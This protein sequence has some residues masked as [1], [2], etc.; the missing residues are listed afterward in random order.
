MLRGFIPA[1]LFYWV[2]AFGVYVATK[3]LVRPPPQE[4][5]P[6]GKFGAKEEQRFTK[7]DTLQLIPIVLS[8]IA[9]LFDL[10]YFRREVFQAAL[11]GILV[12][13][14]VE[15]V[16]GFYELK[17]R[18][19]GDFAKKF[20]K[21]ATIGAS[22]A[23]NVG[24][25]VAGMA[26]I[27]KS[28]T[29]TALAPK[30]SY[31]MLDIAGN[32][33]LILLILIWIICLLFGL[34]VSTLIVYLLVVVLAAPALQALGI[35]LMVSHFVIFYFGAVAFI[36]PPT[37]PASL[38]ASGIAEESFIKTSLTAMRIGIPLFILPF[39]FVTHPELIIAG[40]RTAFSVFLIA[41]AFMGISYCLNS[42]ER[43][44]NLVFLRV[45]LFLAGGFIS[46]HTFFYTGGRFI[47]GGVALGILAFLGRNVMKSF[48]AE[49][50]FSVWWGRRKGE[51]LEG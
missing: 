48:V 11:H 22:T 8:A 49:G 40:S 20:T 41:V 13:L 12:F 34:A 32:S 21:G 36:T 50:R 37:A 5:G 6:E 30:M 33:L 28:L 1:L 27:L 24:V 18:F 4:Q 47:S 43:K 46:F 44:G 14:A 7:K 10:I 51:R 35:P 23:A 15:F 9:I 39:T 3:G 25:M 19:F 45:L 17:M 2:F 38:V 29:T 26:L 42:R 31:L 16:F